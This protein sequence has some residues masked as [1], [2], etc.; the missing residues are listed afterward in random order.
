MDKEIPA[1]RIAGDLDVL[2][3]YAVRLFNAAVTQELHQAMG[4][5]PFE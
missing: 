2:H 1:Q 4:P 5:I 3:D